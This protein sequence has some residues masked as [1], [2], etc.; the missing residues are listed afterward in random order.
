MLDYDC[1]SN[2]MNMCTDASSPIFASTTGKHSHQV[3]VY[4]SQEFVFYFYKKRI[5][6]YFISVLI[7]PSFL[8]KHYDVVHSFTLGYFH[9]IYPGNSSVS[10]TE[11]FS[12]F[13]IVTKYQGRYA[14]VYLTNVPIHVRLSCMV[15][16]LWRCIFR[17]NFCK[18]DRWTESKQTCACSLLYL[19]HPA[20]RHTN[21]KHLIH[22][23]WIEL[24][25]E[26]FLRTLKTFYSFSQLSCFCLLGTQTFTTSHLLQRTGRGPSAWGFKHK[27]LEIK[28]VDQCF[29]NPETQC[30]S[31]QY[32]QLKEGKESD[33]SPLLYQ[34]HRLTRTIFILLK[35]KGWGGGRKTEKHNN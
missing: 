32:S 14:E 12:F 11:F 5:P 20:A 16:N 8:Y 35:V 23:C 27:A 24:K 22:F 15:Q 33:L 7:P 4:P 9:L 17:A 29:C 26:F 21:S 34:N 18:R 19:Q 1:T 30:T 13:S 6:I 25:Y 2:H 28:K 31:K 3:L 10:I